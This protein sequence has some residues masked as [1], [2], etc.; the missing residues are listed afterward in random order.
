MSLSRNACF[1]NKKFFQAVLR[2]VSK[3]GAYPSGVPYGPLQNRNPQGR[4]DRGSKHNLTS[5]V[6]KCGHV[7]D[8]LDISNGN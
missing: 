6:S 5:V 7:E 1:V 8:R 3:A 4:L 2:F